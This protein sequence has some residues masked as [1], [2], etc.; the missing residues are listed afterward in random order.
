MVSTGSREHNDMKG[1]ESSS[2]DMLGLRRFATIT[3]VRSRHQYREYSRE[4]FVQSISVSSDKLRDCS[5]CFSEHCVNGRRYQQVSRNHSRLAGVVRRPS[6][7]DRKYQV[8]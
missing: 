1:M 8:Q 3:E 6:H 4:R 7:I 2:K 5:H